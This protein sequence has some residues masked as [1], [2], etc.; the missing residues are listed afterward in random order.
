MQPTKLDKTGAPGVTRQM[1]NDQQQF[2]MTSIIQR[3]LEDFDQRDTRRSR[4]TGRLIFLQVSLLLMI[5]PMAFWPQTYT[6]AIVLFGIGLLIFLLAWFRNISNKVEQAQIILIVGSGLVTA[7][8]MVGQI[9]WNPGQILPVGLASF[10]FIL[11]I[12]EAGLLFLPEIVLITALISTLFTAFTFFAALVIGSGLPNNQAY[13]LAVIALGLQALTGIIAWQIAYFIM[14]YSAELRRVRNDDFINTQF[15]ALK[16]SVD[17]QMQRIAEQS[18]AL[19]LFIVGLSNREYT[20]RIPVIEVSLKPIADAL[21]LLTSEM[22]ASAVSKQVRR[23]MDD[24][25][26]DLI[27]TAGG[28]TEGNVNASGIGSMDIASNASNSMMQ[29]ARVA[30]DKALQSMQRRLSQLR[31]NT[32]DA[33]RQLNDVEDHTRSAE[34]S[35]AENIATIGLLRAEAERVHTSATR[36]AQLVDETRSLLGTLLPPEVSGQ[37]QQNASPKETH[38]TVELQQVMPGVTIQLDTINDDT[39]LTAADMATTLPSAPTNEAGVTPVTSTNDPTVQPRL[40]EAWSRLEEMVE[41]VAKEVRDANVLQ[42]KLGITSRSMRQVDYELRSVRKSVSAARMIAEKMYHAS[43][44]QT[45]PLTGPYS[46][47]LSQPLSQS[48]P[49]QTSTLGGPMRP[50]TSPMSQPLR[51]S[52][53]LT[54]PYQGA[55]SQPFTQINAAD[56][57]EGFNGTDVQEPRTDK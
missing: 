32:V 19:A 36:M 30:V 24:Q 2:T 44:T 25:A 10:P 54:S 8:N 27:A 57:I 42:D 16:R 35:V 49:L 55:P 23:T 52:R 38:A 28:M 31:D 40:R 48:Q 50:P 26:A 1:G 34:H 29:T 20:N 4:I 43:N 18:R 13:L 45:Q 41:E 21:T 51:Q 9:F 39:T 46:E 56:L 53:P 17:E 22:S 14:D 7:S 6:S 33:A 12:L 15:E 3:E 5:A 11:T 47:P 37:V